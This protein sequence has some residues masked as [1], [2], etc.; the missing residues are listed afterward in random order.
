MKPVAVITGDVIASTQI[1]GE[2]RREMLECLQA[3]TKDA[4]HFMED[5]TP[6]IFQGD[7]FQG[8][9]DKNPSLALRESLQIIMTMLRKNFGIRLSIGVGNMSFDG[10][11]S[12]VSDGTAFRLSGRNLE[13]LK[14]EDQLIAVA[15]DDEIKNAEWQVHSETLN[16]I[17]KR[18]S[19]LQ[20]E[21][22]SEMIQGKTQ[23]E[24]AEILQI[25]QPAVQQ[26]LQASGWPLLQTILQRFESQF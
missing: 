18:C 8:Y 15:F 3:A 22:I 25:K 20:A 14:K 12:N 10:G 16:Y 7:S 9:S 23:V 24:A 1:T 13:N 17:I 2:D 6:E 19:S 21:A 4:H 5:F 11:T 26:R